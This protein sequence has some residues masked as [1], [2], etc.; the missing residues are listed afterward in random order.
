M[1]DQLSAALV[2]AVHILIGGALIIGA[3]YGFVD[4][5]LAN[6]AVGG[7]LTNLGYRYVPPKLAKGGQTT[8]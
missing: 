8:P 3:H 1:S 5:G 7:L 6:T 2:V 4:A